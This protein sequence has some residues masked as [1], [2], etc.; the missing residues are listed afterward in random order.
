MG[1][2]KWNDFSRGELSPRVYG[3]SSLEANR[4]GCRQL[5]NMWPTAYGAAVARSGSEYLGP[6]PIYGKRARLI[7]FQFSTTQQYMLVMQESKCWIMKD[8][9][10]VLIPQP[11]IE[12]ALTTIEGRATGEI[13]LSVAGT[14][15]GVHGLSVGD[16]IFISID[17]PA[18]FVANRLRY[19]KVK[20]V[21]STS[22]VDL[23]NRNSTNINPGTIAPTLNV[24]Y[25]KLASFN[26]PYTE[27]QL[28]DGQIDW[29][30]SKD[31]LFVVHPSHRPRRITRTDHHLWTV[32]N[33]EASPEEPAV[34]G[35]TDTA[36]PSGTIDIKYGVTAINDITKEE[37]LVAELI[38]VNSDEPSNVDPVDL[39]WTKNANAT[40]YRV[41]R[42]INGIFGLLNEAKWVSGL[43]VQYTDEGER[44][45][46]LE[47]GPPVRVDNTFDAAGKYPRSVDLF[48]QRIWFGGTEDDPDGVFASRSGSFRSFA[49]EEIV[50]DSSTIAQVI[51]GANN[52]RFL[53]G[54]KNMLIFTE[55]GEWTFD[56]GQSSTVGPSSGLIS[57]S[58]WGIANVKP[59]RVGRTILFVEQSGRVVRDIGYDIAADGF[60]G[61]DV[62]AASDHIFEDASIVRWCYSRKPYRICFAIL[63]NGEAAAL[64]YDRE[65]E[66]FGWSRHWTAGDYDD[67]SSLRE[68]DTDNIYLS[69][70]RGSDYFIE[71]MDMR[72]VRGDQDGVHLDCW[73]KRPISQISTYKAAALSE[74]REDS[75]DGR[76]WKV[77]VSSGD[78][79]ERWPLIL[80]L[81]PAAQKL[82][83]NVSGSAFMLTLDTS[84]P[85]A[86]DWYVLNR[87]T[88]GAPTWSTETVDPNVKLYPVKAPVSDPMWS[89]IKRAT[90]PGSIYYGTG[91]MRNIHDM[92]SSVTPR[93]IIS[94]GF[95]LDKEFWDPSSSVTENMTSL[96]S[97]KAYARVEV[98]YPYIPLLETME[99]DPADQPLDGAN[100]RSSEIIIRVTDSWDFS[101]RRASQSRAAESVKAIRMINDRVDLFRWLLQ[102]AHV[103]S[104]TLSQWDTRS[105][106]IIEGGR[107][108]PL[109]VQAV[110]LEVEAGAE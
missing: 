19:Y 58:D 8:A 94:P 46:L 18:A 109:T 42:S 100:V 29:A 53:M 95:R 87:F 86:G 38:I 81:F 2:V 22:V 64:A 44:V 47:I 15:A 45:P 17:T 90:F 74:I 85:D 9:G 39:E 79:V 69:V 68:S 33:F 25:G 30:Q 34:V 26:V 31:V 102:N 60:G 27:A 32:A 56:N 88:G 62:S 36:A 6:A 83:P 106:F 24:T 59:I 5:V 91:Q 10:Y 108:Q 84:P 105:S 97:D 71:R 21:V 101:F 82:F 48:Q 14:T 3:N 41:Y 49:D 61:I 92:P 75:N 110:V 57:D 40:N 73:R 107:G 43:T 65:Q 104:R 13:R 20:T 78:K 99:V 72:E 35:L 103:K 50:V 4:S 51:A 70:K 63:S 89:D 1:K 12:P 76:L 28:F 52:I 11:T 66:I 37:S 98:G 93:G 77:K 23:D 67:C 96:N 7:P 55:R 16:V 54:T 80:E